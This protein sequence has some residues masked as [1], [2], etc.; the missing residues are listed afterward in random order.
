MHQSVLLNTNYRFF[1]ND[2]EAISFHDG[3]FGQQ[4]F[5]AGRDFGDFLVWRKDGMP[6]Y[7]LASALDDTAFG[8]TEVVRGADLLKSTARQLLILR[9]LGLTSPAYFHTPLIRNDHG[10]RLAKRDGALGLQTLRAQGMTSAD[11]RRQV[12]QLLHHRNM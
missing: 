8:I 12:R 10:Q 1:V 2:G 5:V 7:Q 9:A 3:N 11:I 6:S 4:C